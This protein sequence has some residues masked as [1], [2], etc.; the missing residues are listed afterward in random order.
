MAK[1]SVVAPKKL[2]PADL[3]SAVGRTWFDLSESDD[4]LLLDTREHGDVGS[5]TPGKPDLIE[6][7]RLATTARNLFPRHEVRV[8]AVDEWV[9]VE[10]F[11]TEKSK[12]ILDREALEK[13]ALKLRGDW[14]SHIE[15]A[16]S[17]SSQKCL[18][19]NVDLRNYA[20]PFSWSQSMSPSKKSCTTKF[21]SEYGERHLYRDHLA[22]IPAFK[23]PEDSR[24]HFVEFV[25]TLGGTVKAETVTNPQKKLTYNHRSPNNV[26][27]EI[28]NVSYD[29]ELPLSPPLPPSPAGKA[30]SR[31]KQ[32]QVH[33]RPSAG[34]TM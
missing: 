9:V 27:E 22:A 6:A 31:Q 10:V 29:V 19:Q 1:P 13:R 2:S 17:A 5:E 15:T 18:G 26:I 21:R 32:A 7:R 14:Q 34:K 33:L 12:S 11:K 4:R 25:R 28:G 24:Q 3:R 20:R 8:E 30:L 23:N 16:L